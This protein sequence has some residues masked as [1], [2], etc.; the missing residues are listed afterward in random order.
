MLPIAVTAAIEEIL[1]IAPPPRRISGRAALALAITPRTLTS[2]MWLM[3][4]S[5]SASRSPCGTKRVIPAELTRRSSREC[6]LSIAAIASASAA[7]SVTGIRNARCPSPN[8]PGSIASAF[9]A[10]ELYPMATAAPALASV[11]HIAAPMPPAPPVTTATRPARGSDDTRTSPLTRRL[12][13]TMRNEGH[14]PPVAPRRPFGKF[15]LPQRRAALQSRPLDQFWR[16]RMRIGPRLRD[17]LVKRPKPARVVVDAARRIQ[18]DRLERPHERP[19]QAQP[20]RHGEVDVGGARVALLEERPGFPEKRSLQAIEDEPLDLPLDDDRR[21]AKRLHRGAKP[22]QNRRIRPGRRNEFNQRHKMGRVHGMGD[23]K[24]LPAR[25]VFGEGGSRN[26][27]ARTSNDRVVPDQGADGLRDGAFLLHALEHR[28]LNIV[29]IANRR[30]QTFDD[31]HARADGVHALN[32]ARLGHV[33]EACANPHGRAA[34]DVLAG[35]EHTDKD[36]RAREDNR[37][38]RANEAPAY[39]ARR[40]DRGIGHQR[41]RDFSPSARQISLIRKPSTVIRDG[42]RSLRRSSWIGM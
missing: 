33:F 11:L 35:V 25:R 17:G 13:A 14:Q 37:P 8:K 30:G 2:R 26:A 1:T 16:P 22:G 32:Q 31:R 36:P 15:V 6:R 24:S 21:L 20:M 42:N 27:G 40:P 4:P 5:S 12:R 3:S 38:G 10:D 18:V 41:T 9:S 19:A 28:F 7:L 29:D 23:K 39:N 34:P